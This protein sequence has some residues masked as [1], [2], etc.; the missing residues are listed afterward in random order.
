MIYKLKHGND[1][2]Y[3]GHI[4][5]NESWTAN[6]LAIELDASFE[7]VDALYSFHNI[8][9]LMLAYNNNEDDHDWYIKTEENDEFEYSFIENIPEQD[10]HTWEQ[11]A[12]I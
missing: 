10:W 6:S 4:G 12:F 3:F 5:A 2:K 11:I 7:M 8:P 9:L 1:I